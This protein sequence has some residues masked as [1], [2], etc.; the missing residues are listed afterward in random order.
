MPN[1]SAGEESSNAYA[2]VSECVPTPTTATKHTPTSPSRTE[3]FRAPNYF[4]L[5][6]VYLKFLNRLLVFNTPGESVSAQTY[7]QNT[8]KKMV[9]PPP[10]L[11]SG[12]DIYV[13]EPL[14]AFPSI[15]IKTSVPQRGPG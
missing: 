5:F 8:G 14:G 15:Q 1:N 9:K 10:L 11:V 6:I 2:L 3:F 13:L 7:T 12:A 4:Q